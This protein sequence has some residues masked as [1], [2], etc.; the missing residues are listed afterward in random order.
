MGEMEAQKEV[1]EAID[2]LKSAEAW[3]QGALGCV[4]VHSTNAGA[5]YRKADQATDESFD[6][7]MLAED[8]F[9]FQF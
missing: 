1:A 2:Q 8:T 6:V 9:Q 7:V 3:V 5:M 4:K